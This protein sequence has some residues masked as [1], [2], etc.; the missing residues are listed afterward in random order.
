M[1]IW[2]RYVHNYIVQNIIEHKIDFFF[3][4]NVCKKTNI[5][6]NVHVQKITKMYL[7]SLNLFLK[8]KIYKHTFHILIL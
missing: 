6:Q 1:T 2:A 7:I 3:F 4:L 8:K 5:E